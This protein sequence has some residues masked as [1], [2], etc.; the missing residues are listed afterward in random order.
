MKSA[1]T[2]ARDLEAASTRAPSTLRLHVEH[3]VGLARLQR[4]VQELLR[5]RQFHAADVL[6]KSKAIDD[7]VK[8]AW[9]ARASADVFRLLPWK[10]LDEDGIP[11]SSDGRTVS[12][13]KA[14]DEAGG[15][16]LVAIAVSHRWLRATA[17]PPHPDNE[18]RAKA[19]SLAAFARWYEGRVEGQVRVFFWIDY[20]CAA[21]D[22]I[23]I[24]FALLPL[25]IAAC[26][27]LVQWR[28]PDFEA[29][30][31]IALERVLSYCYCDG[32]L[33]P[34]IIDSTFAYGRE[35]PQQPQPVVAQVP[36][37]L[38][39]AGVSFE[40]DLYIVR[41]LL[42]CAL[43]VPAYEAHPDRQNVVFG[44]T[45][46]VQMDL[47]RRRPLGAA[48]AGGNWLVPAPNSTALGPA[49]S[50]LQARLLGRA[51]AQQLPPAELQ[52]VFVSPDA[53]TG[54]GVEFQEALAQVRRAV[55]DGRVDD[56]VFGQFLQ[57]M[58]QA[59]KLAEG[60]PDKDRYDR[61]VEVVDAL[62]TLGVGVAVQVETPKL[63]EAKRW[64]C[65][66][67]LRHSLDLPK[68]PGGNEDEEFRR[69]RQLRHAILVAQGYGMI[70]LEEYKE[71]LDEQARRR[72]I[73]LERQLKAQ[74]TMGSEMADL[75][76]LAG[77]LQEALEA[78]LQEVAAN[79]M[80]KTNSIIA[81]R[82]RAATVSRDAAAL[83][84]ALDLASAHGRGS[85]HSA[86]KAKQALA[87]LRLDIDGLK[88]AIRS[89]EAS[90]VRQLCAAAAQGGVN[91]E[92]LQV[93]LRELL[94]WSRTLDD[95]ESIQEVL[96]VVTTLGLRETD[97]DVQVVYRRLTH[98][99]GLPQSWDLL[100]QW[101]S[102][103]IEELLTREKVQERRLVEAVQKL[104]DDTL[105]LHITSD[106]RMYV[107]M[108]IYTYIHT[109]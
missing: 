18:G 79:A 6:Q 15:R 12:V 77:V 69:D 32:G 94:E 72:S 56:V 95:L 42:D 82:L 53:L 89:K 30:S 29:R 74:L 98:M 22:D 35:A 87:A 70:D 25:F 58:E 50:Q 108:C 86:N 85:S 101:S 10:V 49:S 52:G 68:P 9:G 65:R 88:S 67:Q 3:A 7:V 60:F 91:I 5:S 102:G 34:Y 47:R 41:R 26:S 81:S 33:T 55:A 4:G 100:K 14:L 45:E 75:D 2:A 44:E 96:R 106:R 93:R 48:A 61:L 11:R 109:Y 83:E 54:G 20:A 62:Q 97:D 90:T 36:N 31:W 28:T 19:K 103:P 92:V 23:D 105:S 46:V 99:A 39:V 78:Q 24:A 16:L 43:A 73:A 80:E 71:A 104:L 84:S 59:L 21:Q 63:Q 76:L 107:C 17:R 8:E 57:A 13:R 64:L 66:H 27:T 40:S 38:E 51:E 37:P 1:A